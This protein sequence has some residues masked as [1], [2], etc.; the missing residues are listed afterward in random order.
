MIIY[1]GILYNMPWISVI[2][3]LI[4]VFSMG[5]LYEIIN[6]RARKIY[7]KL[8]EFIETN[9]DF[10]NKG[11]EVRPGPYGAYIEFSVIKTKSI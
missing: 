8:K 5:F 10:E 6:T 2:S 3:V 4:F 11:I 7:E 1:T 9:D